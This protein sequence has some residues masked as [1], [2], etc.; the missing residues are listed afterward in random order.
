MDWIFVSH[1]LS[2]G[3]QFQWKA[4]AIF[5]DRVL[6]PCHHII[7]PSPVDFNVDHWIG[8]LPVCVSLLVIDFMM[9]LI[10]KT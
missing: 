7:Y 6:S 10:S 4:L 8:E 1:G 2:H 3:T 5:L 9:I